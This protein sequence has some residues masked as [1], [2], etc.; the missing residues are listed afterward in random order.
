MNAK[1]KGLGRGLGELGLNELLSSIKEPSQVRSDQTTESPTGLRKLSTALL[2]PG[3]YQPR[4]AINQETLAELAES[5]K[6]Q[7]VLQPILARPMVEGNYEIIAGERRWR[8]AQLAGLDTVPVIVHELSNQQVIAVALI[9]NIQREDLNAIDA[10]IGLQRLI[11]EFGMT[12][13]DVAEAVGKSRVTVTNLLRLLGLADTVKKMLRDGSLEM[14]HARAILALPLPMQVR[15]AREIA[16]KGLSVR[17]AEKL[18]QNLQHNDCPKS[19]TA[20]RDP[21]IVQL[22]TKLQNK[23]GAKIKIAHAA[24]G[25]GKVIIFYNSLDELDGILGHIN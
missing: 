20:H 10:A 7:G 23:L 22:Q 11:D 17:A 25:K 21:N 16:V 6:A 4:Q 9:E 12:H 15:V 18:V 13:K 1:K 5:I 14:G 3:K 19:S 24:K 8:A 2:K